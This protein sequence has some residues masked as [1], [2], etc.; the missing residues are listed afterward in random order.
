MKMSR[1]LVA[2]WVVLAS[3]LLGGCA[4]SH[5]TLTVKS[6]SGTNYGR[7]L[8]MVVRKVDPK[9]Y[10]T[11]GY[12]DVAAKVVNPDA[13]VLHSEVIYPGTLQ[14]IQVNMPEGAPVAVSF[15]FTEPNGSW[16]LLLN[17][18]GVPSLDIELQESRI[19]TEAD[20]PV[21]SEGPPP[22]LPEVEPPKLAGSDT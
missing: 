6:P 19:L 16:Q 11:E 15:L 2:W 18:P 10:S 22:A 3:L 21:P 1:G 4:R 7:P 17:N 14:R 13:T 9:Q 12:N 20:I 5:V 8:Y